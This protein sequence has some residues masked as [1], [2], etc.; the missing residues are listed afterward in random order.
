MIAQ[1]NSK[2]FAVTLY[3]IQAITWLTKWEKLSTATFL[4]GEAAYNENPPT[5]AKMSGNRINVAVDNKP[6][7]VLVDSGASSSVILETYRRLF[8][9]V[10]FPSAKHAVFK[11]A[12]GSYVRPIGKCVLRL[13]INGRSFQFALLYCNMHP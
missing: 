9:K 2:K 6:M 3:T 13:T 11:S 1:P 12:N 4:G 7:Y 8:R 10:M 5:A